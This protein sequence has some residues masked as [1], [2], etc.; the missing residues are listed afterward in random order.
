LLLALALEALAPNEKSELL[1]TIANFRERSG[2]LDGPG[3]ARVRTLYEKAK[4]FTKADALVEK[5]RARAEALA[6]EVEPA[7]FRELLYYLVDTVLERQPIP[8]EE[9]KTFLV[10]LGQ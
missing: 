10:Q 6:D 5:Y 4:V 8:D 7:E 2:A 3:I 9:A 1:Q